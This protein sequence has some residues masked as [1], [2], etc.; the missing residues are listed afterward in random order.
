VPYIIT[1]LCTN[2]GACVEVCPVA[3]IHTKP[4]APQFYVDPEVCIDCEQCE[5]VC[6]VDAIFKDVDIPAQYAYAIEVNAAFFR[7]NKAAIGPVPFAT[8]WAMIESAH[9]YASLVGSAITAV[10]VDEAGAPI[11]VG[12][13]DKA[14]ARSAELAF[15]KAY[16]AAA[17]HVSTT[18]LVPQARQ[19]WLRSLMI[20][21]RGKILPMAG[22]LPIVNGVTIVGA[23]G[24]AGA[25]RPEQDLLCCRAGMSVWENVHH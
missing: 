12:K 5:I 16:T 21:H 7:Q 19:P 9:E 10:V 14:E 22:A 24:I 23:I 18:E 11:A 25:S 1:E 6:P 17:F 13:M 4:G 15:N 20:S 2:D 3:C 8:A